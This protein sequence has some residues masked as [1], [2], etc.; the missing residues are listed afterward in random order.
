MA[1]AT[2]SSVSFSFFSASSRSRFT[3]RRCSTDVKSFLCLATSAWAALSR[4]WN[5]I[6]SALTSTDASLPFDSIC[7]AV[8]NFRTSVSASFACFSHAAVFSL[9]ERISSDDSSINL[10]SSAKMLALSFSASTKA[11]A[12]ATLVSA[13]LASAMRFLLPTLALNSDSFFVAS[14]R[15]FWHSAN[16]FWAS[17]AGPLENLFTSK[18]FIWMN[19]RAME[20]AVWATA[21]ADSEF[22]KVDMIS[23]GDKSMPSPIC[24]SQSSTLPSA[25][26]TA[27]SLEEASST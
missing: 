19:I 12:L 17:A 13:S 16:F 11:S 10:V 8:T 18:T 3:A 26:V 22:F 20:D 2:F 14:S 25:S 15:C 4:V 21:A 27:N 9:A 6:S 5:L 23:S 24:A 1:F 7:R